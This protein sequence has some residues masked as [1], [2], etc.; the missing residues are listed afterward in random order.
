MLTTEQR[1]EMIE[2]I[3]SMMRSATNPHTSF[4]SRK[5]SAEVLKKAV[6]NLLQECHCIDPDLNP[7]EKGLAY[8]NKRVQAI[9]EYKN[10]M[11]VTLIQ[12]KKVVDAYQATNKRPEHLDCIMGDGEEF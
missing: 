2:G 4:I 11:N 6:D 12:A 8:E 5:G 3:A 10:R 7:Y 1:H 9:K